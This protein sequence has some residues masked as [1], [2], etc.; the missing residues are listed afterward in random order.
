M[1]ELLMHEAQMLKQQGKKIGQI[2]EALGK[3]ER[4]VHYYLQSPQGRGKS[5]LLA[6]SSTHSN[7]TLILYWRTIPLSIVKSCWSAYAGRST[8]EA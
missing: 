6:V 3:S 8:M 4:M 1:L 2:A 5:G 7:P